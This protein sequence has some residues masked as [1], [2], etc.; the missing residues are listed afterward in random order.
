MVYSYSATFFIKISSLI[1]MCVN[2]FSQF[3]FIIP[4][5]LCFKRALSL[6]RLSVKA[7]NVLIPSVRSMNYI[8]ALWSDFSA[9]LMRVLIP[10]VRSM[11]YIMDNKFL[12]E[13]SKAEF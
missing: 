10:S 13:L 3:F 12:R 5:T 7:Q 11:N 4:Y 9:L 2:T 8:F 6:G 1:R